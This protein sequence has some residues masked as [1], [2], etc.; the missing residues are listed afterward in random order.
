MVR[1]RLFQKIAYLQILCKSKNVFIVVNCFVFETKDV[2]IFGI[3]LNL[4]QYFGQ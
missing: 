4:F 3:T 2:N 1:I